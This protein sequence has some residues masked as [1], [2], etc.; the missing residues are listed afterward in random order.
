LLDQGYGECCACQ[1]GT[2]ILNC[3]Y[4]QAGAILQ[5]IYGELKPKTLAQTQNLK[6]LSQAEFVPA[7]RN[8]HE[9]QMGNTAYTYVPS[10]CATQP[11]SCKMHINYHGCGGDGTAVPHH[12]GF[13]EWAEANDIIIIYPQAISGPG[14]PTGCWDWTGITGQYFDTKSGGQ[15]KL[16]I[17]MINSFI[18][19]DTARTA[20]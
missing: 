3:H 8:L 20:I 14:N 6:T 19:R 2:Y 7:G 15:L 17:N 11:N 4:D 16:V 1:W 13:N 18:T 9:L 5:H 10:A 12:A